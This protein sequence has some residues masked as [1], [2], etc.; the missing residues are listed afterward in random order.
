MGK[1]KRLPEGGNPDLSLLRAVGWF[2]QAEKWLGMGWVVKGFQAE[3][4]AQSEV[5]TWENSIGCAGSPKLI[6]P[7]PRSGAGRG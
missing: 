1:Q 4:I 3:G 2:S 5:Q 7:G 6:I